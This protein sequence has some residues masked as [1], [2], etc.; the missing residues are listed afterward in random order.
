MF[1]KVAVVRTALDL[2]EVIG[3]LDRDMFDSKVEFKLNHEFL[4]TST[5]C[6]T[7]SEDGSC[8]VEVAI[9]NANFSK[10]ALGAVGIQTWGPKDLLDD[11]ADPELLANFLN[12]RTLFEALG[13]YT[14]KDLGNMKLVF[15]EADHTVDGKIFKTP[16]TFI[17]V[18]NTLPPT[19]KSFGFAAMFRK[20]KELVTKQFALR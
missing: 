7:S 12:I 18:V 20:A 16:T 17:I 9:G 19:T 8:L 4:L 5:A 14:L 1:D 13:N 3:L 6:I 10:T 15:T 11:F 2:F